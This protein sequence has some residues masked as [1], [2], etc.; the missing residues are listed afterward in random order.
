MKQ[1]ERDGKKSRG[2]I[3]ALIIFKTCWFGG[4]FFR[5][6]RLGSKTVSTDSGLLFE[7]ERRAAHALRMLEEESRN[8]KSSSRTRGRK[9]RASISVVKGCWVDFGL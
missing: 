5:D 6:E 4:F 9:E 2:Y 8:P 3:E 1:I 7:K